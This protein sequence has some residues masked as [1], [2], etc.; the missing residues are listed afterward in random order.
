MTNESLIIM[1]REALKTSH[2]VKP[3]TFEIL[4]DLTKVRKA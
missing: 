2:D 3:L 4:Q 1:I